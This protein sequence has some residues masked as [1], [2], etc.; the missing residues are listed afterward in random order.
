[1][2]VKR[3]VE[4]PYYDMDRHL[5]YYNYPVCTK[6]H[7]EISFNSDNG[8]DKMKWCPLDKEEEKDV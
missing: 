5:E 7:S 4:C 2:E 6:C 8:W 1:M 3:C